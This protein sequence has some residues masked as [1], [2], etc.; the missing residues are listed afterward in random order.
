[1]RKQAGIKDQ[2]HIGDLKQALPAT[3]DRGAGVTGVTDGLSHHH[4][5]GVSMVL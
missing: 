2:C 5:R 1:M 3:R 4:R